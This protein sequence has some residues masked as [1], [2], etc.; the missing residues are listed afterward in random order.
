MPHAIFKK[1][2]TYYWLHWVFV[3]APRLLAAVSSLVAEHSLQVW[4]SVVV[5]PGLSG[6][7]SGSRAWAQK[8]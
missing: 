4:A 7:D 1:A 8:L 2:F 3:A 5:A 6:C